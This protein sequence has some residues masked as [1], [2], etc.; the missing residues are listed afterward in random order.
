MGVTPPCLIKLRAVAGD[1]GPVSVD[2]AWAWPTILLDKKVT[3]DFCHCDRVTGNLAL[4][5][6]GH[7]QL[8]DGQ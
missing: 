2:V 4:W 3:A 5:S 6:R 1:C 7:R 8:L